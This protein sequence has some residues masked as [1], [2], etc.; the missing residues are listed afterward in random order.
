MLLTNAK[1]KFNMGKNVHEIRFIQ[2][3]VYLIQFTQYSIDLNDNSSQCSEWRIK[4][5]DKLTNN[6][7]FVSHRVQEPLL[8]VHSFL[9]T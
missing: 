8:S 9:L 5:A 2:C 6:P 3:T 4:V 7:F 1:L